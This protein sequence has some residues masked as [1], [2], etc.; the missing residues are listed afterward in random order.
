MGSVDRVISSDLGRV[1][2]PQGRLH[3]SH[4]FCILDRCGTSPVHHTMMGMAFVLQHSSLSTERPRS[5]G[6]WLGNQSP[7]ILLRAIV[8]L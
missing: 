2:L 3:F 1:R 6:A 7:A 8:L 4:T 5:A